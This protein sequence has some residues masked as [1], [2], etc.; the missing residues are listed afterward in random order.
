MFN[1]KFAKLS[2]MAAVVLATV[3][4]SADRS[5]SAPKAEASWVTSQQK[6]NN[7]GINMRYLVD[8]ELAVGKPVSVSLE[9]SGATAADAT[10]LMRPAARLTVRPA[11]GMQ[12]SGDAYQLALA[13]NTIT[14]RTVSF[15]PTAEG[16]FF[17]GFELN[18]NGQGSVVGIMLRV[19]TAGQQ[20]AS[21]GNIVTTE[22]GE[23]LIV[24]PSR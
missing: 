6:H 23:K 8:G 18:Q 19:G 13:P 21:P 3:G 24:M 20:K 2:V 17:I 15:T 14:A 22:T 7:S 5:A 12:K 1:T 10:V 9:F 11:E 16:E 4:C